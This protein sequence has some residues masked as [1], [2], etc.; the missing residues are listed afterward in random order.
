[1]SLNSPADQ[2]V[3]E[4]GPVRLATRERPGR[5]VGSPAGAEKIGTA[6]ILGA[7]GLLLG[8]IGV[9]LLVAGWHLTQGTSGVGFGELWAL[10]TGDRS[11]FGTFLGKRMRGTLVMLPVDAIG[12]LVG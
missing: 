6:G 9:L 1:M 4:S 11:D 12:L 2:Q 8:L 7:V 10:A 5:P 3:S